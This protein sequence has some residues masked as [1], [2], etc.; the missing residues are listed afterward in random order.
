MPLST[1]NISIG[2]VF[3][4]LEAYLLYHVSQLDLGWTKDVKKKNKDIPIFSE[5][6]DGR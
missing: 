2:Q 3:V 5:Q 4:V 1:W 6:N